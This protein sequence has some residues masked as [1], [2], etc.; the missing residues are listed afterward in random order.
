MQSKYTYGIPLVVRLVF[1]KLGTVA[2]THMNL[3]IRA[4]PVHTGTQQ[5][6]FI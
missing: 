4:Q 6:T 1:F 3:G 2:Q 5:V